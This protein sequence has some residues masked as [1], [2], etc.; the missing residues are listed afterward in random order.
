MICPY[1]KLKNV[2]PIIYV[3]PEPDMFMAAEGGFYGETK[4]F[5]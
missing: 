3:F 4:A 5:L 2:I 1:C